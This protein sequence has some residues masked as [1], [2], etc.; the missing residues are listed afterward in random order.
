M[1]A[2]NPVLTI[3]DQLADFLHHRK[4]LGRRETQGADRR[5]AGARRHRRCRPPHGRLSARAVGRHAPAGGHRR[6]AAHRSRPAD[7]RRADDRARRDDGGADH[8]SAAR[9][10]PRL[11]RH[12][13]RRLAPSRRHRR[14]LRPGLCHVCRR[15]RRGRRRRR[16]LPCRGTSLHAR[17]CSPA[18]PPASRSGWTGCRPLPA[19]CRTS[20]RCRPAASTRRAV[21]PR[22]RTLHCH[23]PPTGPCCPPTMPSAAMGWRHEA[24]C[25][26]SRTCRSPIARGGLLSRLLNPFPLPAFNVVDRRQPGA[27]AGRDARPG[28]RVRLRQDD[29]G[30]RHARADADRRGPHRLR[31]QGGDER[32]RTS[33]PCAA[34]RR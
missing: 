23:E 9:A 5:H 22:L 7:R 26:R 16:H 25:W 2:F 30:A 6:R 33:A 20:P 32:R 15:G 11:Q 17:R 19:A 24:R 21:R 18:I 10:A 13:R 28:R 8:P 1:T 4:D 34:A 27:D 14:A 12:H 29:A 31:G 3:G